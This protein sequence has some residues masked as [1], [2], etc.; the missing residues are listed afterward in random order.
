MGREEA[1]AVLSNR[2]YSGDR[3]FIFCGAVIDEVRDIFVIERQA[4]MAEYDA[5]RLEREPYASA[6]CGRCVSRVL[7]KLP[8]PAAAKSCLLL[9]EPFQIITDG[10]G[11]TVGQHLVTSVVRR[12][13]ITHIGWRTR[14]HW[15]NLCARARRQGPIGRHS[16]PII[17]AQP[18]AP[19]SKS[20]SDRKSIPEKRRSRNGQ[21]KRRRLL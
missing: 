2:V 11:V 6:V 7:Q 14:V 9:E 16:P 3:R 17:A 8:Y 10:L 1:G 12:R 15:G 5:V 21:A 13:L 20:S 18:M 4:V 19:V